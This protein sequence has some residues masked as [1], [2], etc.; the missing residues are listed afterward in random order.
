VTTGSVAEV[1]RRT[2]PASVWV[3]LLRTVPVLAGALLILGV[4]ASGATS[5]I[6]LAGLVAAGVALFA[7]LLLLSTLASYVSWR[8]R[9]FWF[10]ESGD[11]R[12]DSG[13]LTRQQRRLALSR[14]QSVDVQQPLIARLVGLAEVRVEV[15]GAGDSRVV[16]QYLTE[17]DAQALRA[18]VLARAAGLRPDVGTAPEQVLVRVPPRDLAVSLLVS[19]ATMAALG[20]T[21]VVV[22]GAVLLQGPVGLL[23]LLI[24]GGVPIFAAFSQF[25]RFFSFTVAESP[26]GLRVRA[27]LTTT[28]TQTVPPGRVHALEVVEPLLWRRWGWVRVNVTL[29]GGPGSGSEQQ[30]AMSGV[31]LP[32]APAAVA[33][34]LVDRVLPGIG[35][36][37]YA[38]V[39]APPR[40]RW[41]AP[42][43][44][45]ALA[46]ATD[47][48]VVALRRGRLVRRVT[49]V[50]HARVQS[51]HLTQGPLE[52]RL[53]L[54]SLRV[55]LA[56]G[57]VQAVGLRQDA[58]TARHLVDE[59]AALAWQARL[60]SGPQRW[61]S[62]VEQ[63]PPG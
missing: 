6:P 63:P 2:H 62:R 49:V 15:A 30:D 55:D 16:L 47:S 43:Q 54:A 9:T 29:A 19:G 12:V 11:L 8:R 5:G 52:R 32:V 28:R 31:L 10:D 58:G 42:V 39:P 1:P 35:A 20:A 51:V 36:R 45:R 24:G 23:A 18:E 53:A 57:P 33:Q 37:E 14:L 21:I 17:V 50:P 40:A 27:G 3:Q 48:E 41:R 4:Q 38:W 56:P 60:G 44:W 7:L 34:A 26:D 25:V 59:V 61:M 13:V 22:V 46:V